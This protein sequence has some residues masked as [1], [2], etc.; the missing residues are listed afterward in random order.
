ML[1][2]RIRLQN[3]VSFGRDAQE[4]DLKPL[5]VLIG[6]N[7][8]G[9][10][11]LIEAIAL[12]Q[13]APRELVTPILEGGGSADWLWRVEPMASS[14]A[15][16]IVLAGSARREPLRYRLAFAAPEQQFRLIDERL[17]SDPGD[18][19]SQGAVYVDSDGVEATVTRCD[20]GA[21]EA[22]DAVRVGPMNSQQS[23]L[24]HLRD[25][26]IYPQI[27]YVASEMARISLFR[28]WSFGRQS[29]A[30]MPQK[31]DLPNDFLAEDARNLGLVLNRLMRDYEARR[32]IVTALRGLYEGVVDFHVNIEFGTVQV[33]LQEGKMTIPA[34]RLSDG[35]LRYL[36]LLTI[37][38]H[39]NPPPLVCLEE[40][41]LGLHPDILP[42]LAELLRA[43]SERCQLIV[44]THSDVLVDALTDVPETV[45][46]CEKNEGQTTMKRLEKEA[47]AE[48]LE[49]Y[50]LGQL[51]ASGSIGG[52]RW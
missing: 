10:S 35:T 42:G 51:W 11:N 7:G 6:T 27:T 28:E 1:I 31:P 14:G 19:E 20:R 8:S 24:T 26:E 49:R 29:P 52:N 4:L 38:C 46:V 48:W 3:V 50:Q 39:P 13:A 9:K 21:K 44:T 17:E 25:P 15:M 36:S 22:L 18:P 33:F 30:R 40:P 34:T 45:V 23:I 41:E 47:L 5:N 2:R 43:A 37:L 16:E 32:Q 12:L